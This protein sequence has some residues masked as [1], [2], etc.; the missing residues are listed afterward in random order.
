ML[1][2][3]KHYHVYPSATLML[4]T[5][6]LYSLAC[7]SL[8]FYFA[9][10]GITVLPILLIL[11]LAYSEFEKYLVSR[12]IDPELVTLHIS[13]SEIEWESNDDS[14]LFTSYTVYT[15]RWGMVLKLR[16]RWVRYNLIF[17]ADRF[18]DKNEYL[19]LRYQ[20]S[21]LQQVM[22]AS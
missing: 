6:G 20:L 9:V 1:A 11:L 19:D 16:S 21:H 4:F 22:N 5:I 15:S 10:T 18:K 8:L 3:M 14:R 13:T 17:L 7:L 2:V 12:K